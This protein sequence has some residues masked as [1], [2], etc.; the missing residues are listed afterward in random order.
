MFDSIERTREVLAD[1]AY[2]AETGL[3]T[4]L[5]LSLRMEKPLFLEGEP[6]VGKTDVARVVAQALD[7]EL[8]RL[9]CYEGLDLGQAVY[10]WDYPRQLLAIQAAGAAAGVNARIEDIFTE[11]FLLRRP[12]LQAIDASR[13]AK[14]VLLID[15]LDRADE[16]FESFLLEL[17]SDFQVTVPEIGTLSAAHTP[18]VIIT[19]N[20]TREIHDAL[21]RRCVYHWIDF[22]SRA[23]EIRIVLHKVPGIERRLADHVVDFVQGLR[24]MDLH[25]FPGVAET[26]DWGRAL[27]HLD[28]TDLDEDVVSATLGFLIKGQDDLE[29]VRGAA[30][31]ELLE[32]VAG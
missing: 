30:T 31:A 2:I 8:I 25:K 28:R 3:C 6:G 18:I 5:F 15:E 22:P 24:E 32:R 29:R 7:T 4:S 10:E 11:A 9:Q 13:T 23:K 20:R 16:E 14:P 12:L 26:L 27:T 17:L 21:K 19:S 1:H